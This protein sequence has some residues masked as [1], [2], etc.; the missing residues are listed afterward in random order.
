MQSLAAPLLAIGLSEITQ[1][2]Y[3]VSLI[4]PTLVLLMSAHLLRT[5]ELPNLTRP[6]NTVRKGSKTSTST[7]QSLALKSESQLSLPATISPKLT[8]P[9]RQ[10]TANVPLGE[11]WNS[12]LGHKPSISSFG[13]RAPTL[14]TSGHRRHT[15]YGSGALRASDLAAEDNMRKTLAR[16]SV[17]IWLE[18]GHAKPPGNLFERAT[19][20]IKPTPAL[21]IMQ[22]PS[23]RNGGQGVLE[24]LRGGVVSML[25]KR[26]SLQGGSD[27]AMTPR[28]S[29]RYGDAD[30]EAPSSPI[31]IH[32]TSPSKYERR[33]SGLTRE[34]SA[35]PSFE[36]TG[37][38]DVDGIGEGEIQT[39]TRAR[40]SA[41]PTY[42]FGRER[43]VS[44]VDHVELDW[45]QSAILPQ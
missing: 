20:M 38:G 29:S 10:P 15:V 21:R 8:P 34:V 45:L 9:V 23:E 33:Q 5:R 18:A 30:E 31:T 16:R 43:A 11:K 40:M 41:S 12:L 17:D 13:Y 32:I 27:I 36:E 28:R 25:P 39:A 1:A 6:Q 44:G 14:S 7:H 4:I 22:G 26:V 24:R 42:F 37:S 2:L 35:D 19:E 3:L